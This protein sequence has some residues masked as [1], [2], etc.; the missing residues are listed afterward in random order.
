MVS[1]VEHARLA[2]REVGD[3][4]HLLHFAVALGLDLAHLERHQAA[5]VVLVPRAARRRRARTASPRL[6]RRHVAP[7]RGGLD[8]R[9]A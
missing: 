5:E 2:D 7:G 1:A 6:R 8:A 9:S 3:V 4:D